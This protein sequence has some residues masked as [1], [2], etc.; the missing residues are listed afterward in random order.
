MR[1]PSAL[2]QDLRRRPFTVVQAQSAGLTRRRL[3]ASD[4]VRPCRGA[5]VSAAAEDTLL[6]RAT[7]LVVV[8]GGVVSHLS[9]ALLWGFP[10]PL[11]LE[12]IDVVHLTCAGGQRA[13]RRK[14]V[15]GHQ[16]VLQPAEITIG[17]HVQCTGKDRHPVRR[18]SP[19][20]TCTTP[21]RYLPRR[22]CQGGGLAGSGT[23]TARPRSLR[24]RHGAHCRDP[25]PQ[26]ARGAWLGT[27][28]GPA[29]SF[30]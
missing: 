20:V 13:V 19:C 2:P 4:L 6:V 16:L 21:Q 15:L 29:T 30:I 7:A 12:N 10:V 5:R 28:T 18:R 8:T 25:C 14:G 1:L 11:A 24:G 9:A 22:E 27:G 23:D 26:S 17:R 3:R